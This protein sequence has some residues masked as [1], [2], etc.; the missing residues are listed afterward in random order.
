MCYGIIVEFEG[1]V[2]ENEE[3][4]FSG[5]SATTRLVWFRLMVQLPLLLRVRARKSRRST[6]PQ[7]VSSPKATNNVCTIDTYL[8]TPETVIVAAG[9]VPW[10]NK[11]FPQVPPI[12][13]AHSKQEV[14]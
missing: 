4:I 2:S 7:L 8:P 9:C 3:I 11:C 5:I 14:Q 13:N 12:P 10:Y 1:V 6:A